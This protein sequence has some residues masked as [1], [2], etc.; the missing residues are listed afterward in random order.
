MESMTPPTFS[1]SAVE[2]ETGLSK[3]VLRKWETRYGFPAPLRDGLGERAYP[4]Q[5]VDRLRLIKRLMDA[6]FR[7]SRLVAES[8]DGLNALAQ[9]SQSKVQRGG[10]IDV[11]NLTLDKLQLQDPNGLRQL[12]YREMLRLG[13]EHFVLDTL[14]QLNIAVGDAWA[15]GEL[16]V[17]QEH[18]YTE[19]VQWLLRDVVAGLSVSH[20]APRVLLTTLPDEQHSLGLLMLAALLSLRG[21]YCISLGTQT[22]AQEI[23]EAAHAY[24][25][26]IVALSFSNAYPQRR[27]IPA[28]AELRQ[29]LASSKSIWAGGAGCARL[30]ASPEG[31][32]LSPEMEQGMA[33]LAAWQAAH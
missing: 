30:H 19:A 7:P 14:N 17:H 8:E 26:D 16:S 11:E 21:A 4:L 9:A 6:G 32:Y 25:I 10:Q 31:T 18:L 27:I 15:R 29:Q 33:L 22:P 13:I 2:R 12:L 3:D 5:Q 24:Q 1:I 23:I 20:G 28:L